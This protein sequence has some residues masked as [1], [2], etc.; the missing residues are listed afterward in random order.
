MSRES[1]ADPA[2]GTRRDLN[3]RPIRPTRTERLRMLL[4]RRRDEPG[5]SVGDPRLAVVAESYDDAVAGSAVL[6]TAEWRPEA[7]TVLRHHLVLPP[8]AIEPAT[9]TAALD[10]YVLDT[11]GVVAAA[12][13][14]GVTPVAFARVQLVDALHLA[15]ER[16][17][18]A[19]LAARHGGTV[20][21]WQL[22]QLPADL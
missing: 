2:A 4:S 12:S 22:L 21:G 20:T 18:M 1:D 13:T 9:A 7:Q 16:S 19:G 11:D 6:D 5:P 3:G 8:R 15:Q 14:A 10:E 17:R